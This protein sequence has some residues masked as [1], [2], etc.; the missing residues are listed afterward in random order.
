MG[1]G[2]V[3]GHRLVAGAKKGKLFTKIS[4]E[5][6]VAV[7]TGGGADPEA[8]PRLRLALKE[9]QKNSMPKDTV[10]RALK[11]GTGDSQEGEL[12]EILYEGYGA[13]GVAVLVET[14]TDNRK[15]TV[16]DL[17]AMFTRASGALGAE[18]SV[19]WMF[20]RVA[21]IIAKTDSSEFDP[22]EVAINAGANDVEKLEGED[23]WFFKASIEDLETVQ[24]ALS[25]QGWAVDKAEL[26]YLPKTPVEIS[27]DQE[28]ILKK[29]MDNLDD[30]DD[31]KKVHLAI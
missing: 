23:A 11:R 24:N 14:L 7:K 30:H 25:E 29:L 13:N 6:T 1:R 28:E 4:K 16:Q 20:D 10:D 17:R 2:W 21:S 18:G 5:I 15:R 31:V 27:E 12:E 8:N 19:Q 9:A 22:E 3:H 26:V